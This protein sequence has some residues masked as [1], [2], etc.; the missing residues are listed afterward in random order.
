MTAHP[1]LPAALDAVA[2]ASALTRAVQNARADV[3]HHTKNDRS[4]VTVADYAA[5]AIVSMILAEHCEP[6]D[7]LVVG[8]EQADELRSDEQTAIRDAVIA[9]VQRW[10]PQA[11][12]DDVM[13][14]IDACDHDGT[15]ESYWTLD[16]IDGTKGFLRGQQYAIALGRITRGQVVL[17]VLGCPNLPIN[18]AM[19]P[20]DP[21]PAGCG[22]LY[23]AALGAGAWEYPAADPDEAPMQIT[24]PAWSPDRPVRTCASVEAGHSNRSAT[25]DLLDRLGVQDEPVRLDSQAKYAVLARGQADAYL[26][27]PT[28]RN[29][30][31]K[32]WDHAA[33]SL[34]AQEAGAVV[35]DVAGAPLDFG[36][37]PQLDA[38]RGVI[39]AADGLHDRLIEVSMALGLSAT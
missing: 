36:C 24:C 34:V 7:R 35:T 32:I 14:A 29:Y 6:A 17:G 27:L 25:D 5:Q 31:E 28:S 4:P 13:D 10:R 3:A 8:E 18:A 9:V 20:A 23:A 30:I 38:N 15:A 39:A 37:G 2:T 33:G 11:S 16:P 21:D 19:T 22:S 12:E 1:L 26:R